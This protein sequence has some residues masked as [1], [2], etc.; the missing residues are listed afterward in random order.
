MT[1]DAGKH[2]GPFDGRVWLNCSHQGPLPHVAVTAMQEALAMKVAPYPMTASQR[3]SD[4]PVKL[5]TA[6][7]RLIGADANDVILANSAS[8]GLNVL[9]N[10]IQ[11]RTGDEILLVENDFPATIFPWLRLRDLGVRIR[12]IRPRGAGATPADFEAHVTRTTRLFCATWVHSFTGYSLDAASLARVCKNRDVLFVLNGSQ[13]IGARPFDVTS[14]GVDAITSCGFKWLCGPYA[15]GFFWIRPGLRESMRSTQAYWLAN[16]SA[17]D[18]RGEFPLEIRHDLGARAYDVFCP[19]NFFNF[20]PWTASI[21]YLLECGLE[22]VAAHNEHLVLRLLGGIDA[23]KYEIISPSVAPERSSIVVLRH[24]EA[25]RNI[26]VFERLRDRGI[27]ISLRR[28][29]LRISPHLYNTERD[30]D[31]A[32]DVLNSAAPPDALSG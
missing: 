9:A 31:Q 17:D 5:R 28:G 21:E 4:V 26:R 16:L 18:L 8:Y 10:G 6:L 20:M 25:D 19:A 13:G 7:G 1:L 30:I 22:N 14:S 3:F 11:W 32:L 24:R 15:T 27:D 12:F 23:G 2:F 29:T